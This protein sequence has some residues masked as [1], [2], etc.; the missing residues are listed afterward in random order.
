MLYSTPPQFT[1]FGVLNL[2][3]VC[4]TT[5]AYSQLA[6]LARIPNSSYV[7]M[8]APLTKTFGQSDWCLD[9]THSWLT[10]VAVGR[11]RVAP[12]RFGIS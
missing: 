1:P 2:N 9:L 3:F 8:L 7:I 11:V 4:F 5:E 10:I 6:S 12:S